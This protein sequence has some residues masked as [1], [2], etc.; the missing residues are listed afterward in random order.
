MEVRTG[1]VLFRLG[2]L[3]IFRLKY[4]SKSLTSIKRP[5]NGSRSKETVNTKTK[6]QGRSFLFL[7]LSKMEFRT[8][9]FIFIQSLT[10]QSLTNSHKVWADC[11]IINISSH[12]LQLLKFIAQQC[13]PWKDW[14]NQWHQLFAHLTSGTWV[15]LIIITFYKIK[16][17]TSSTRGWD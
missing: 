5:S 3:P 2:S 16:A 13:L 7:L 1:T 6:T 12:G 15:L 8:Y 14:L 4:N 10:I 9:L 17:H 11:D